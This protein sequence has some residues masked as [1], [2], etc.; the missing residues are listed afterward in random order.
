MVRVVVKG[1]PEYVIPMCT[2]R[3][4]S[5]FDV[6]DLDESEGNDLLKTLEANY[7]KKD[8]LRLFTYA[9][10]D[11]ELYDFNDMKEMNGG[12]ATIE[13]R[14]SLERDLT[15][16]ASFGLQDPIRLGVRDAIEKLK[17]GGIDVQM[18]SGDNIETARF[19]AQEVGILD[20][21]MNPEVTRS[22]FKDVMT[23]AEFR[24]LCG[25]VIETKDEEGVVVRQL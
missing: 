19:K 14:Q 3:L 25:P 24:S 7:A 9:Y 21:E 10:K 16:I 5:Q 17:T 1:A 4:T 12:F 11:Y 2:T 8:G 23:G 18:I 6:E 20:E 22:G 13:N 15:H